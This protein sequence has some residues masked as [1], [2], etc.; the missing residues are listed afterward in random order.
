MGLRTPHHNLPGGLEKRGK[1]MVWQTF[2]TFFASFFQSFSSF[3]SA[4][5]NSSTNTNPI[6]TLQHICR[7]QKSVSVTERCICS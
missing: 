6:T 4:A 3:P 2:V 1:Q 7:V 5:T